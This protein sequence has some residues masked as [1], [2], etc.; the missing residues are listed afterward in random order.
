MLYTGCW[1]EPKWSLNL[2]HLREPQPTGTLPGLQLYTA[3]SHMAI[4]KW[5]EYIY[6]HMM[7][8]ILILLVK[9]TI[10]PNLFTQT[11]GCFMCVI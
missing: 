6:I 8:K 10:I 4:I 5:I 7:K 1:S 2:V 11:Q 9:F 3:L